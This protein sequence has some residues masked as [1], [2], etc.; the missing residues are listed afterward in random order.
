MLTETQ[1]RRV[2]WSISLV[3][4]ASAVGCGKSVSDLASSVKD[5]ASQ[6]VQSVKDTAQQVSQEVADKARSVTD[7]TAQTLEMAGSM[8][9]T[10]DQPLQVS[11]CYVSFSHLKAAGAGVLQLQSYRAAGQESFP[12]VF[13]RASCSSATLAELA[14][15]TLA[16]QMFVQPQQNGPLWSATAQP[17]QLKVT[18]VAEKQLKAEIVGGSLV[19]SDTGAGQAVTGTFEGVLP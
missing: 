7:K 4:A 5:A 3:V 13:V 14:G 17:I 16:A 15:Q 6:G 11:A 8:R 19:H 2:F 18:S 10:I 1:S 9:L 12:S